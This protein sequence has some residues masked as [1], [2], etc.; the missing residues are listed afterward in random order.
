METKERLTIGRAKQDMGLLERDLIDLKRRNE[1]IEELLQTEDNAQF[2][3]VK[4][5]KKRR[6]TRGTI[7]FIENVELHLNQLG[8]K[9]KL[10]YDQ[11]CAP[12]GTTSPHS[13]L[14]HFLLILLLLQLFTFLFDLGDERVTP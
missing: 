3:Q 1:E 2:F 6:S 7:G 8:S 11:H 10:S 9:T 12:T 5:K 14:T 4:K 13:Q